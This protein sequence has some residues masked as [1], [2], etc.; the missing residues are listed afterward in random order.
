MAKGS[1]R[2]DFSTKGNKSAL[3]RLSERTI[4]V[5][6]TMESRTDRRMTAK[7]LKKLAKKQGMD[8]AKVPKV[9]RRGDPA[10][11]AVN[12]LR[13]QHGDTG[14]LTEYQLRAPIAQR[15]VNQDTANKPTRQ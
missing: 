6:L 15:P 3:L 11:E 8:P 7:A 13:R 14:G 10:L 1:S 9:L 4:G 2:L 5:P 12:A